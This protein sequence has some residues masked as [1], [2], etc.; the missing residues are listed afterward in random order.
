MGLGLRHL[1][2]LAAGKFCRHFA[3]CLL[4]APGV[5]VCGAYA[6]TFEATTLSGVI[7]QPTS[8]YY[9]AIYGL[10]ARFATDGQGLIGTLRYL[11]RPEFQAEGYKDKDYG[12]FVL[13]GTKLTKWTG[14]GIFAHFGYGKMFGYTRAASPET[15]AGFAADSSR[16]SYSIRGLTAALEYNVRIG[17][18]DFGL[19]HQTFIGYVDAFQLSSLVA[20]PFNVFNINLG[21]HW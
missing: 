3:A 7:Q 1:Y 15:R 21:M 6:A 16:S 11:E 8:Q 14:H 10:N 13:I 17:S 19:G 18:Y 4:L 2:A 20:W 9:H 5:T 12:G